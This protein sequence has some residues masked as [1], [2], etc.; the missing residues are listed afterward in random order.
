LPRFFTSNIG[1]GRIVIDGAD[2]NHIGR[3]LRMRPGDA[4]TVCDGTGT[5]YACVIETIRPDFVEL[6][7]ESSA[8]SLSEPAVAVH[9]FVGM[10]KAD[11]AEHIV[12]K[13]VELGAASVNFFDCR[14][15]V[16][17]PADFDKRR[18]RLERVALEAAKQSG[19]G[20]IPEIG[21]LLKFDEMLAAVKKTDLPILF[22]EGGGESLR[23]ILERPFDTCALITGPEGGFSAEEVEKA[24][25]AGIVTAT[26]GPRILRCETAPL[27]AASA[28]L[29]QKGALD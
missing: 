10:P 6:T 7:I 4:V 9:L 3:T 16:S 2:A 29:F 5:D 26:L 17:K 14:F 20:K 11:K 24:K 15:C 21:G 12:Q 25:A 13:A 18:V 23:G 8:P 1:D 27:C 22:Y 19:R 28:V